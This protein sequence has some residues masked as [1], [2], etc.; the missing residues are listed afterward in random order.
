MDHARI[1]F[2]TA[3]IPLS[4]H[5]TN[6]FA[7]VYN[8][9]FVWHRIVGPCTHSCHGDTIRQWRRTDFLFFIFFV[10]L[11]ITPRQTTL[12]AGDS[13]V[14]TACV[15]GWMGACACFY[16][17]EWV[18]EKR[19]Q[20]SKQGGRDWEN[21]EQGGGGERQG[22]EWM[23]ETMSGKHKQIY[24]PRLQTTARSILQQRWLEWVRV[25]EQ[26]EC[27]GGGMPQQCSLFRLRFDP[28]SPDLR[29]SSPHLL[30]AN[31]HSVM[32]NLDSPSLLSHTRV[33]NDPNYFLEP[34]KSFALFF[35]GAESTHGVQ[36]STI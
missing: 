4:L 13:P 3:P 19:R 21:D 2:L 12:L 30:Q 31:S 26:G 8:P 6:F 10:F 25:S 15:G 27:V 1:C 14:P 16:D 23:M 32:P 34:C 22:E 35:F 7:K 33:H 18:G 28:C 5:K 11:C 36:Y 29:G 20:R 9:A 24:T 17:W